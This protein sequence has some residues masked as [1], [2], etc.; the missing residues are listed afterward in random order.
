MNLDLHR[1]ATPT[2]ALSYQHRM[3][4]PATV[5][6]E[7]QVV[8]LLE[9]RNAKRVVVEHLD[10]GAAFQ[11]HTSLPVVHLAEVAEP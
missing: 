2:G 9:G 8:W 5:S 4:V 6:V 11:K 3:N 10:D 1:V 7:A